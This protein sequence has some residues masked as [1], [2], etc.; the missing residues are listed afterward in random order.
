MSRFI[1]AERKQMFLLPPSID[2]LV[3]ADHPVRLFDEIITEIDAAALRA[4]YKNDNGRPAYEPM[5]VLRILLWAYLQGEQSSR[6]IARACCENVVYMY[7]AGSYRPDFRTLC[8]F[9]R[10]NREEFRRVLKETLKVGKEM[11]LTSFAHINIDG[12]KVRADASVGAQCT[13]EQL[14][15]QV[16]EL[17]EAILRKAEEV[18]A[19]QDK[20]YGEGDGYAHLPKTLQGKANRLRRIKEAKKKL[21]ESVSAKT[22]NVTDPESTY[23]KDL[24]GPGYNAQ[25]AVDSES[26]LITAEGVTSNPS[27]NAQ[28]VPMVEA[29]KENTG[30]LNGTAAADAGYSGGK[31]LHNSEEA[32]YEPYIPQRENLDLRREKKKEEERYARKDFK[33]EEDKDAY[34]CPAGNLLEFHHHKIDDRATGEVK[35]RV[36]KC[37]ECTSCAFKHRC[38]DSRGGR[39]LHI[40]EY[41]KEL[42]AVEERLS[43]TEGKKRYKKRKSTVETVFG[44]IKRLMRFRRFSLR[45]LLGACAEWSL[46]CVVYNIRRLMTLT[47]CK[48]EMKTATA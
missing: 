15:K 21:D 2:E 8:L 36:Y 35:I 45:G 25:A 1:D 7:L 32:G 10:S 16:E 41:D 11:S 29:H 26:R 47:R 14:D 22:A 42:R 48:R 20:E 46:V 23:I 43:T 34:R 39:E 31:N 19:A 4:K 18:D 30:T 40:S 27:D 3:A 13:E 24:R 5:I 6:K 9:R 28:L 12:T 33:Y 37:P 44:Q 17:A 38:T